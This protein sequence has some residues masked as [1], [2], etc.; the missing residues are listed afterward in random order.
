MPI[1]CNQIT[2]TGNELIM[3]FEGC[4]I[5]KNSDLVK[6]VEL[7]MAVN[8]CAGGGAKYNTLKSYTYE[9]A[10]DVV[11]PVNSFHAWTLG[12]ISGS[13][14]YDGFNFPQGSTRS[15]EYTTTNAKE[16]KFKVNPGS[17][18][19]FEYLVEDEII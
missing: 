13:I 5:P 4:K 11:W 15:V 8:T 16:V 17:V 9:F 14:F 6:L 10:E 2:Q 19:Y 12:V 3:A 1:P 18:V 7:I